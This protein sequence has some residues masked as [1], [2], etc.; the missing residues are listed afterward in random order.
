MCRGWKTLLQS[1]TNRFSERYEPSSFWSPL[2]QQIRLRHNNVPSTR[3][4]RQ[5]GRLF[6]FSS[7]HCNKLYFAVKNSWKMLGPIQL[8]VVVSLENI[9]NDVS[10]YRKT[11]L[12]ILCSSGVRIPRNKYGNRSCLPFLRSSTLVTGILFLYST[13]HVEKWQVTGICQPQII[14]FRQA[15]CAPFKCFYF[16]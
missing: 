6:L 3:N 7:S 1:K 4:L 9:F 14:K 16:S 11:G 12:R 15:L 2:L 13:F 5:V 8:L 10:L